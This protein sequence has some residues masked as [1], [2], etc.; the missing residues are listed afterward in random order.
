AARETRFFELGSAS[1]LERLQPLVQQLYRIRSTNNPSDRPD[2]V[3]IP[4]TK[5]ARLIVTARTNHLAEIDRILTQLQGDQ[6]ALAQRETRVID[7][8]TANAAE[9]SSTVRTLYQEQAKSRPGAPAAD[10]LILPDPGANR[11]IITAAT[12]EIALVEDIIRKL[13]KASNQ[14]AST[15]VFKVKSADPAKVSEILSSTLVRFDAFGRPQRRVAVSVDPKTR[16]LIVTG[17]PKELTGVASIIEQLDQSLGTQGDRR[18][19]V[20]SIAQ[21]RASVLVPRVRQLYADRVQAQ[22][23]LGTAEVLILEEPDS[24]QLV[25]AGSEQQ[26]AVVEQI[27]SDLQAAQGA[28]AARETRFFE[29]GSASELERL[30]PLVQQLYRI[31]STNNPSDRPDAVFIPDT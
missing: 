21:G 23:D 22:P 2:A 25:L 10:T 1:E 27:I 6:P 29:L 11:L 15:R 12:N 13:D 3:F 26:L 20:V 7:L 9:L 5:N 19:K 31:R 4:D 18:M 30:Q 24:N 8:S 14:S 16:T 28:Q 17:D